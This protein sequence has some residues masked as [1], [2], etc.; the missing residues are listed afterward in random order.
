MSQKKTITR[1]E[2]LQLEGLFVLAKR[3]RTSLDA[4][5]EA[6]AELLGVEDEGGGYYGIVSDE[7]IDSN[8]T[9]A[10]LLKRLGINAGLS[11]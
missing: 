11:R 5:E 3:Y 4:T 8:G 10:R 9:A 1:N 6:A 7:I 2:R